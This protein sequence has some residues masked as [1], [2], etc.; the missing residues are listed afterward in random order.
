MRDVS[1]A[2]ELDAQILLMWEN[3]EVGECSM[4]V[5]IIPGGDT[6]EP[7][8][9]WHRVTTGHVETFPFVASAEG[10]HRVQ[11]HLPRYDGSSIVNREGIYWETE[12]LLFTSEFAQIRI[13]PPRTVEFELPKDLARK[14]LAGVI[15]GPNGEHFGYLNFAGPKDVTKAFVSPL[16]DGVELELVIREELSSKLRPVG[17]VPFTI[18]GEDVSVPFE[19]ERLTLGSISFEPGDN[20]AWTPE[21]VRAP[22]QVSNFLSSYFSDARHR[23][24]WDAPPKICQ[25]WHIP[26]LASGE[27]RFRYYPLAEGQNWACPVRVEVFPGQTTIL[28]GLDLT[29]VS[30]FDF[31]IPIPAE[32]S[33]PNKNTIRLIAHEEGYWG[34]EVWSK[35]CPVYRPANSN[36]FHLQ[37]IEIPTVLLSSAYF[38]ATLF[39]EQQ[40]AVFSFVP[41]EPAPLPHLEDAE[42]RFRLPN[43]VFTLEVEGESFPRRIFASPMGP[44]DD[45][46][47]RSGVGVFATQKELRI[48][49]LPEGD[50]AVYGIQSGHRFGSRIIG[51]TPNRK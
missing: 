44:I 41:A 48:Y 17:K 20:V 33:S 23:A 26:N 30:R 25:P 18:C 12:V 49:G 22:L 28:P 19:L 16:L 1:G 43:T 46:G 29:K 34:D 6:D 47:G 38:S 36:S 37:D 15:R 50:Y 8:H 11:V 27:Y 32:A 21:P 7:I 35:D 31:V 10:K 5:R 2:Q 51:S 3:E 40:G 24:F 9:G 13:P 45:N 14:K 39:D 42:W 4:N